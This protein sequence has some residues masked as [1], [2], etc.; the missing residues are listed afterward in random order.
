M[1]VQACFTI[2]LCRPHEVLGVFC[3]LEYCRGTS[4]GKALEVTA[5]GQKSSVSSGRGGC[6]GRVGK[7]PYHRLPGE[8]AR[9]KAVALYPRHGSYAYETPAACIL[10]VVLVF[11]FIGIAVPLRREGRISMEGYIVKTIVMPAVVRVK[12][13]KPGHFFGGGEKNLGVGRL[14]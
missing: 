2:F 6:F 4:I 14:C 8:M 1:R 7:C 5:Y 13:P 11:S 3:R 10:F 12:N 9:S